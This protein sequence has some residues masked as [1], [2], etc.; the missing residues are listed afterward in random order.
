[1]LC[2]PWCAGVVCSGTGEQLALKPLPTCAWEVFFSRGLQP[3][4]E[5]VA[6]SEAVQMRPH[7]SFGFSVVYLDS[8]AKRVL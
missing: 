8:V 2:M 5:K 6:A 4:K 3:M 7:K 1:M